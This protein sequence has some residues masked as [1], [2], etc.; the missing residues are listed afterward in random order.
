M[1]VLVLGGGSD[2]A[3]AIVARLAVDRTVSVVLAARD[4]DAAT[5][6]MCNA[7]PRV[8]FIARRWDATDVEHHQAFIDDVFDR[9][10]SIDLVLCAVGMLGHHAGLTMSPVEVD[11]MIRTNFAGPAAALAAVG[12]RLKSQ[13][14][15]SVLVLSSVAGARARKS[16][17]VYGS[18]KSGLDA[19]AQG[20]G[21]ALADTA[22]EVI[23]VRPGFVRSKMTDGLD[24]APF[25]RTPSE[26]AEAVVAALGRGSHELWVPK[27][28]GPMM[29]VLR[30]A[31]RPIWRRIA[32]NR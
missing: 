16:N 3:A 15:G 28:L 14:H 18:S 31:P 11:T 27:G 19:F 6:S 1:K 32:S 21:D 9:Y 5:A 30:N 17:Y 8:E 23:V 22:V 4:I 26:V 2:I 24:P 20:M 13:G 12:K 29:S 7:A 25:S 10:G